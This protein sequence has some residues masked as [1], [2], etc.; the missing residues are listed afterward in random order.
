MDSRACPFD[1]CLLPQRSDEMSGPRTLRQV[2]EVLDACCRANDN[3]PPLCVAFDNH[4]LQV[5]LT[6]HFLGLREPVALP[7]LRE[8]KKEEALKLECW[9]FTSLSWR[10]QPLFGHNDAS[11]CQKNV[12][13][14]MRSSARVIMTGSMR[15]NLGHLNLSGAMPVQ[16]YTGKDAQSDRESSWLLNPAC[17]DLSDLAQNCRQTSALVMDPFVPSGIR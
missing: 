12:T 7:F 10:G 5:Q 16:A 17:I 14:A 13:R 8:C 9:P 3:I 1:V 4:I 2:A 11:H 6:E 15:V